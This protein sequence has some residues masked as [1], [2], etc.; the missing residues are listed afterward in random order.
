MKNALISST[1]NGWAK[2]DEN[3]VVFVTHD[4]V[5]G[6]H[7]MAS[8]LIWIAIVNPSCKYTCNQM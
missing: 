3:V 8:Y 1:F 5:H 7:H 2:I 4:A 6:K